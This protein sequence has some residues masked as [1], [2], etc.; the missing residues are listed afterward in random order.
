VF[1]ANTAH[2]KTVS[3]RKIRI[4]RFQNNPIAFR[5]GPIEDEEDVAALVI[6]SAER[7]RERKC[8]RARFERVKERER[9][10]DF[11]TEATR[12]VDAR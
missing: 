6:V 5:R 11:A 12:M 4:R 10:R 3:A 9:E 7:E 1:F 8:K 2:K